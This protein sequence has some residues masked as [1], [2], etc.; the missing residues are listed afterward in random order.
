M[1][2]RDGA[3]RAE[4]AAKSASPAR[5]AV[6]RAGP[7]AQGCAAADTAIKARA[8]L[9]AAVFAV[10][11]RQKSRIV[12]AWLM[13]HLEHGELELHF[14]AMRIAPRYLPR[15]VLATVDASH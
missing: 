5:V 14:D 8:S 15:H 6:L 4:P 7:F 10:T 12:D 11:R 9:D 3:S 2:K 13:A 1:A